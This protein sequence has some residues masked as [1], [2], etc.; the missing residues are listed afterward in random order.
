M[1]TPATLRVRRERLVPA[2]LLFVILCLLP[3]LCSNS[4][5]ISAEIHG[6]ASS[7]AQVKDRSGDFLCIFTE[8]DASAFADCSDAFLPALKTKRSLS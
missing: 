8:E 7:S 5:W 4:P 3:F 2:D 1:I 6:S